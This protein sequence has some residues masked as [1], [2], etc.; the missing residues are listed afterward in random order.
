MFSASY[1]QG[2]LA[3]SRRSRG[4]DGEVGSL[5]MTGN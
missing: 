1:I 4:Y 5:E 2:F 3:F